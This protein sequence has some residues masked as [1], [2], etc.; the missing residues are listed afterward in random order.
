MD[1]LRVK[2]P[3][4]GEW[5]AIPAIQ[6]EAGKTPV[7]GVDYWTEEDKQEIVQDVLSNIPQYEGSFEI[8]PAV[9]AQTLETGGKTMANDLEINPIPFYETSNSSGGNTAIIGG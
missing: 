1:I 9:E 4:T 2:D 7:K 6:G 5:N 8:T 3:K